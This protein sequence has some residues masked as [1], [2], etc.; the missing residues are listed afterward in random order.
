MQRACTRAPDGR[1]CG[2]AQAQAQPPDAPDAIVPI[3]NCR[4]RPPPPAVHQVSQ[5][6]WG[7]WGC[8]DGARA[9]AHEACRRTDTGAGG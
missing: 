3:W 1:A 5:T 9:P 6:T 2:Q 7:G 8:D 4:Q